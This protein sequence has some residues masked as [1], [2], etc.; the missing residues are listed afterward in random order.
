MLFRSSS[1]FISSNVTVIN[2][3]MTNDQMT[4]I[5][6]GSIS[7]Y[8]IIEK[9]QTDGEYSLSLDVTVSVN[10]LGSFVTNSGGEAELLGGLFAAKC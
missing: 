4:M 2:D 5:N 3:Q 9:I 6:N 10:K 8:K 7:E 1:V